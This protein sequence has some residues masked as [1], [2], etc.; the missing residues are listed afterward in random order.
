MLTFVLAFVVIALAVLGM[1]AGVLLGRAPIAGSCGGLGAGAAC[2]ACPH[3]CARR[4]Q[5]RGQAR[6][7]T[8]VER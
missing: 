6:A 8:D 2:V 1:A 4:S 5:Q 7:Q 3:R